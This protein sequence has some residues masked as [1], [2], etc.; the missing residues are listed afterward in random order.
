MGQS[1]YRLL[2][3]LVSRQHYLLSI[4]AYHLPKVYFAVIILFLVYFFESDSFKFTMFNYVHHLGL[5]LLVVNFLLSL[6]YLY[7]WTQNKPL[8]LVV[9]PVHEVRKLAK[10]LNVLLFVFV[11]HLFNKFI[12]INFLYY[13]KVALCLTLYSGCPRLILGQC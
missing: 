12:V 13:C 2:P 9:C 4:G 3:H 6:V 11:M 1:G 7:V 8:Q 10:E 5:V